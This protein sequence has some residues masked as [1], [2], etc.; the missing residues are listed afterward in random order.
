MTDISMGVF[1]TMLFE[2]A[3]SPHT[4]DSSSE[5][6]EFLRENLQFHGKIV[7]GNGIRGTRSKPSERT[8]FGTGYVYG[9]ITM[10][11]SAGDFLTLLPKILGAAASG[12]TFALAED[13][14]YFGVLIQRD[15]GVFE[16]QDC[17]VDKCTIRGRPAEINEGGE[18]ELLTMT[19]DLIGKEEVLTTSWPGTP[20]SISTASNITPYVICDVTTSQVSATREISEFVLVIDNHLDARAVNSCRATSIRPKDR[21]VMLATRV[22]WNSTN[23]GLYNQALS[24]SVGAT[25]T[26]AITSPAISTIFTF[27]TLQT[28]RLSPNVD[29]KSPVFLELTSVAR[30]VTTTKELVVTNDS[31]A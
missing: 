15:Y 12:T 8:R 5:A 25:L 1:A 19:L 6:Y 16:Y 20:P 18:P 14:P 29:G 27:A 17:K 3:A 26:F 7:G 23:A 31:T 10:N 4:F 11:I 9:S 30:S 13:V 24:G 22:P 21:T 2:P 28:P